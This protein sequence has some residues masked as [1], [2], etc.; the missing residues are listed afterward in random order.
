MSG[1]YPWLGSQIAAPD[2]GR[3]VSGSGGHMKSETYGVR[4]RDYAPQRKK[5]LLRQAERLVLQHGDTADLAAARLADAAFRA[6]DDLAGNHWTK[7]FR[8]LARSHVRHM[9]ERL[10]MNS[11]AAIGVDRVGPG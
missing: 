3:P 9:R 5:L 8:V 11:T 2:E 6:G 4:G 1:R 7:I 10:G